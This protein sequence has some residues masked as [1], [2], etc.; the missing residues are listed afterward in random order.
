MCICRVSPGG[1][2]GD[3]QG[4]WGFLGV[5]SPAVGVPSSH[6]L[7]FDSIQPSRTDVESMHRGRASKTSKALLKS[8]EPPSIAS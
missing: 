8:H 2:F 3:T 5:I 6:L 1:I 7:D 4:P